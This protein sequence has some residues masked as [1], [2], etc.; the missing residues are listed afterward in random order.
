MLYIKKKVQHN[1]IIE[2]DEY[3]NNFKTIIIESSLHIK[4]YLSHEIK[5]IFKFAFF[6]TF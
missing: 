2:C 4:S 6:L 5:K 1:D 3:N